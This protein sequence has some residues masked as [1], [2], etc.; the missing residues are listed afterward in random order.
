MDYY[1]G[2]E[3]VFV[4]SEFNYPVAHLDGDGRE[5]P[6]I[7][8]F[9]NHDKEEA[10]ARTN[11]ENRKKRIRRD[12]L[13][14]ILYNLDG[15]TV[16]QLRCLERVSCRNKVVLTAKPLPEIAWS[17]YIKP[18]PRRQYSYSYLG[19]DLIGMRQF[20]RAFDYVSFLNCSGTNT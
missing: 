9:F 10:A 14:I 15:I 20:E 2:K 5:I 1:L 3:L 7:T 4:D 6:T 19:K 8:V 16:D 11:W 18:N 12:N 17:H 13:F